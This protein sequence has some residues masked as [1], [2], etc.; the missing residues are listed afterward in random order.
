MA[1]VAEPI[2]IVAFPSPATILVIVKFNDVSIVF[3]RAAIDFIISDILLV[4]L[5]LFLLNMLWVDV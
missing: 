4:I 5:V 3:L 2:V 1:S